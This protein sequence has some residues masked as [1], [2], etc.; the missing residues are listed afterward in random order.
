[1]VITARL[2]A[3]DLGE[4]ESVEPLV[5]GVVAVGLLEIDGLFD[6][7]VPEVVVSAGKKEDGV[8]AATDEDRRE[9][10]A[11]IADAARKNETMPGNTPDM[12][13]TVGRDD[14]EL[15][16]AHDIDREMPAKI[17]A[18]VFERATEQ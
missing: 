11:L 13:D 18:R 2:E 7:R 5:S 15:H 16:A 8:F 9:D 4:A 1:M 3:I 6:C 12:R 17:V 14:L 10:L